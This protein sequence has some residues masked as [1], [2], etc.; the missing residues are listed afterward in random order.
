[1]V[2]AYNMTEANLNKTQRSQPEVSFLYLFIVGEECCAMS[3]MLHNSSADITSMY[4]GSFIQWAFPQQHFKDKEVKVC[5]PVLPR[6]CK[7]QRYLY[8]LHSR[9]WRPLPKN[10]K[11]SSFYKQ[12][13]S[14]ELYCY[15]SH[16][17]WIQCMW[18]NETVFLQDAALV[19]HAR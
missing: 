6:K 7:A 2:Y 19:L 4:T 9:H 8:W 13:K 1:M 17:E 18:W 15:F 11:H 10:V 14:P 3:L 16:I 5:K 12:V